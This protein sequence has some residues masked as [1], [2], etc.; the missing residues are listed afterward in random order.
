MIPHAPPF[1]GRAGVI[2]DVDTQIPNTTKHTTPTTLLHARIRVKWKGTGRSQWYS[3]R[4]TAYN[5]RKC[6]HTVTYDDGEEHNHHLSD[7][8]WQL[9]PNAGSP[10]GTGDGRKQQR[11][12]DDPGNLVGEHCRN[13]VAGEHMCR[14][15][16]TVEGRDLFQER[17]D[18]DYLSIISSPACAASQTT[19]SESEASGSSASD[20]DGDS[21]HSASPTVTPGTRRVATAQGM[22]RAGADAGAASV[23]PPPVPPRVPSAEEWKNV[24]DGE[25]VAEFQ[26][27]HNLSVDYDEGFEIVDAADAVDVDALVDEGKG[28]A[29]IK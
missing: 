6:V 25:A 16:G 28:A 12:P 14:H 1:L 3:G 24:A 19:L 8:V 23:A 22:P 9:L 5:A 2:V 4:V 20:S 10:G 21:S 13:L 15:V 7:L 27:I 29:T 26:P 11:A 17:I 18:D